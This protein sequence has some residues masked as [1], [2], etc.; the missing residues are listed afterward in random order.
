MLVNPAVPPPLGAEPKGRAIWRW[1]AWLLIWL[2]GVAMTV[3]SALHML[4]DS[5]RWDARVALS[6]R[7][8]GP[9]ANARFRTFSGGVV[10]VFATSLVHNHAGRTPFRGTIAI[11]IVDRYGRS[12]RDFQ[13]GQGGVAH[14]QSG[15]SSWTTLGEVIA[16]RL[17][18]EPWLIEARV[19]AGDSAF[20]ASHVEVMLRKQRPDLGMGGM[21]YYVTIF[22]G[23]FFQLI[24]MVL[25]VA[26]RSTIGKA[27]L[28][29]SAG[30]VFLVVVLLAC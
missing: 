18:F 14:E 12:V 19:T 15:D 9:S 28:L 11:R 29:V 16:P 3:V 13:V 1:F 10:N 23:L 17:W 21:V 7:E 30:S 24:A 2:P 4:A 25:A 8:A 6:V 5:H 27:P 20:P 26:W 22:L